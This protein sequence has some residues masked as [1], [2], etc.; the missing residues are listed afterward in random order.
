[1][2]IIV[3]YFFKNTVTVMRIVWREWASDC[4]DNKETQ[5]SIWCDWNENST[6]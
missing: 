4:N 1:M 6:W 3:Q 2:L 5:Y